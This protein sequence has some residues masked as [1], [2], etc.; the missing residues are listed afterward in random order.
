MC[1]DWELCT[2]TRHHQ[3][4]IVLFL[5]AMRHHA[6]SLRTQNRTVYYSEISHF[7]QSFSSHLSHI[8]QSKIFKNS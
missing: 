6:Q 4:K 1:E 8:I 7:Q 3:Q 5:A 2:R